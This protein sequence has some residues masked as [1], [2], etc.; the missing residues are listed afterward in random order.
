MDHA[1]QANNDIYMYIT[2]FIHI[3]K[4]IISNSTLTCIINAS[5]FTKIYIHQRKQC[6]KSHLRNKELNYMF[7]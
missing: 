4:T 1:Y 2:I 7:T 6:S 3:F 5:G